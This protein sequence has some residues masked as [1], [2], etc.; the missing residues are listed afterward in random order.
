MKLHQ[1]SLA[2]K[3]VLNIA[4][5]IVVISIFFKS[6]VDV[7]TSYDSWW[8]HLPFAARILGIVP[9]TS[10]AFQDSIETIYDGFP[11]L[12]EFLQ[13][14]FWVVFQRV[15]AA[16]L[17]TFLSLIIYLY[18]LKLYFQVPLYLSAFALLSVP[19][20]Q[21][22]ATSCYVD[23]PAN[24]CLSILVM[25]TYLVYTKSD[26][27]TKRNLFVIFLAAAGTANIKLQLIPLVFLILCFVGFKL[28]WLGFKQIQARRMQSKRLLTIVP[29]IFLAALLIFATPIKNIVFYGNPFYPVR[30]EVMGIVLNH[31]QPLYQDSPGYLKNASRPQRWVYSIL[32]INSAPWSIDQ[33]SKNPSQHRMGGFFGAYVV[34]NLLL[35]S[36]ICYRYRC[37][38]TLVAVILVT[39]MSLVASLIPQSHEL[40]YYMFWMISLVSLNL[41][42]VSHLERSLKNLKW[43]DTKNLGIICILFLTLVIFQIRKP[44][45]V[46]PSFYTLEKHLERHV[47]FKL[48][49]KISPGEEVCIISITPNDFLYASKFQTQLNYSYSVK[50]TDSESECGARKVIKPAYRPWL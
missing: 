16:N 23:L 32:E 10:Y 14:L 9:A 15:Q 41:Y 50:A 28:I 4:A 11:L 35:F 20:I 27:L 30:I 24:V 22:H 39:I 33:G 3:Y 6:L 25:M 36:Y 44:S 37:R 38:E 12:A 42:L 48:V 8:Y 21:I 5:I 19:L 49:N 34:F 43:I 18:F 45:A 13:G 31:K 17:V 7:D 40:R 29:T 26:F 47:D 46:K 1:R 2:I